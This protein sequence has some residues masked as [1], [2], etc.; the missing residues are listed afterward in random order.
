MN[1]QKSQDEETG[2]EWQV[3]SRREIVNLRRDKVVG[4]WAHLLSCSIIV[5]SVRL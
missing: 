4:C 2:S 5:P 3:T 1:R